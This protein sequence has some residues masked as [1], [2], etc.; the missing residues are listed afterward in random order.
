[1]AQDMEPPSADLP[2]P[3]ESRGPGGCP[4]G[5]L[6]ANE[7]FVFPAAP[8]PGEDQDE[9]EPPPPSPEELR[10]HPGLARL[11]E[12]LRP[13]L[14]PPRRRKLREVGVGA[15]GGRRGSIGGAGGGKRYWG[16]VKDFG[17]VPE[18]VW[19]FWDN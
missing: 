13:L 10:A 5:S 14:G 12:E 19:G 1:M 7:V 3:G 6:G 2:P 16:G 8:R 18:G 11:L 15:V 4:E 9:E 17:G